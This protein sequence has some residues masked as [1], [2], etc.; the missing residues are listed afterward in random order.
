L[1]VL[2]RL[3][4]VLLLLLLLEQ[5]LALFVALLVMFLPLNEKLGKLLVQSLEPA[6]A[7]WAL[8]T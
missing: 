8:V 6:Q 4:L 5:A 7:A 2:H 1:A 3:V